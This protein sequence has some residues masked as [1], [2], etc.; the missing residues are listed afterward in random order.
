MNAMPMPEKSKI[1]A[2]KYAAKEFSEFAK[3]KEERFELIDG[4]I[5][6]MASP[7][8]IHQKI[9]GF[10]YRKLGDYLDQKPCEP[11]ISP[12]DV[13]LSEKNEIWDKSKN[14][15]QPD[16]F[17]VCD[18]KKISEERITGAPDFVV[19]VTS[20]SN[21][22]RDYYYK[23]NAYMKYGVKEYWIINPETKNI[24]VYI[25]GE[26]IKTYSFTFDDKI[27]ASIFENFE[28]DFKEI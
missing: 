8:R 4:R 24:L 21:S 23:C 22:E 3:T 2:K 28:I 18:P 13:V 26:E 19:E 9:V 20:P 6:M 12:F 15:F 10:I 25:N 5:I 27:K 17:V 11:F 16:V 14:V 1:N 7:K